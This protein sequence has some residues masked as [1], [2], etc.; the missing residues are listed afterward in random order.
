MTRLRYHFPEQPREFV[1]EFN[2]EVHVTVPDQAK[3][4]ADIIAMSL[5]GQDP[6]VQYVPDRPYGMDLTDVLPNVDE[7]NVTGKVV[8]PDPASKD[9]ASKDP[10]NNSQD[11]KNNNNNV[12]QNPAN[13]SSSDNNNPAV[14]TKE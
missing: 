12:S 2:S 7:F 10:A 9:P 13:N 5:D 14:P 8:N 4:I 6:L 3:S 1:D 11:P